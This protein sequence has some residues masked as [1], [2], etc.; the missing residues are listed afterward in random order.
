VLHANAVTYQE[1]ED[2]NTAA[3]RPGSGTMPAAAPASS[4]NALPPFPAAATPVMPP[5]APAGVTPTDGKTIAALIHGGPG[6]QPLLDAANKARAHATELRD[7]STQLRAATALLEQAWRSPAADAAAQRITMLAG[8][9]DDHAQHAATAARACETQAEAFAHTRATVPRPEVF[10]DLERRLLAATRANAATGGRYTPVVT[11]LQT[12][13]ATTNTEAQAAYADYTARAVDLG[14]DTPTPP[15]P[16]NSI[17]AVDYKTAPPPPDPGGGDR[18]PNDPNPNYPGRTNDGKYGDGNSQDGKAAE[19]AALDNRQEQLGIP[20]IRDQVRATHPD[21][22][23]PKTG[24]PQ[25][26]FYDGLEPTGVPG[27]YIGVEAKTHQ[28]VGLTADQRRFDAAVTP[29][30]PATAILNGQPIKIIDTDVAY[31]P[32]GWVPP[33]TIVPGTAAPPG[34]PPPP[35]LHQTD[36]APPVPAPGNGPFPNWGTHVTPGEAAQSGG[37]IGNLGKVLE[38]FLPPD[39]NDP[40]NRA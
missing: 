7:I 21:V 3:L 1:Q 38:Q 23:N 12:Q 28:G 13:L 40:D 30:H 11:Q 24:Q 19:K 17:Q 20:I 34:L 31:P 37:E 32:Q 6:P 18:N 10:E 5:L 4:V 16:T 8:W 9:Y 29:Q 26:R 22:T 14:A 35:V 33:P 36:G 39:P 25:G 15:P 27:E 2:F